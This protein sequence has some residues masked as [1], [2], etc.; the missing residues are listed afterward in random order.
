MKRS[1]DP[2]QDMYEKYVSALARPR[3][4]AHIFSGTNWN[5]H[6]WERLDAKTQHQWEVIDSYLTDEQK[7]LLYRLLLGLEEWGD[8]SWR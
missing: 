7:T 1:M 5:K 3:G 6:I 8:R 4:F 2:G